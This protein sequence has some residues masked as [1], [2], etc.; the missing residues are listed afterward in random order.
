MSYSTDRYPKCLRKS[1][2]GAV[3]I[4]FALV[5]TVFFAVF[6]AIVSYALFFLLQASFNHAAAEGAR[7]AI[8]INSQSYTDTS[9]YIAQG[10]TPLVRETVGSS[11]GWLPDRVREIVLGADNGR[12]E[13]HYVDH[14]LTVRVAYHDYAAA[15]LLPVIVLPK[16]GAVFTPVQDLQGVAVIRLI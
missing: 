5:F 9:D 2:R 16:I 15:P 14:V 8:S 12:V 13:V 7:A 6:Y 4:E 1:C 11:L 3:A 10:V